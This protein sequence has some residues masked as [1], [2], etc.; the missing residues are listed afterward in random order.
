MTR[1]TEIT[2]VRDSPRMMQL[3]V[4]GRLVARLSLA[5]VC[6]MNLSVGQAWTDELAERV[7]QM[8]QVES[9]LQQ[10]GRW[11]ARRAMSRR[12]MVAR[13]E[14]AGHEPTLVGLVMDRLKELGLLDDESLGRTLIDELRRR[15]QAGPTLLKKK[16]LDRGLD[17]E[18]AD[19]LIEQAI[20][21]H[22]QE[23]GVA[24]SVA[25]MTGQAYSLA[26]AR[27]AAWSRLP[28]ATRQRRL[29]SLLQRRG[30]DESTIEEVL[31]QCGLSPS[32]VPQGDAED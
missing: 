4:D 29:A 32:D 5:S 14:K 2:A 3:V 23:N 20:E 24:P 21:T 25:G 6:R 9:A 18:L 11:I 1:I 26:Q 10:A 17:E 30:Y 15:R 13:L 12:Q 22:G 31:G 8:Q 19:R 16:L 28:W 7:W 27:L